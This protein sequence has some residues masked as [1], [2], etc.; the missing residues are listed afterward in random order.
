MWTLAGVNRP[1]EAEAALHSW[2]NGNPMVAATVRRVDQ[3]AE[4]VM[5]DGLAPYIGDPE[6]RR[7]VA[8][9]W[10]CMIAGMQQRPQPLDHELILAAT[11]EFVRTNM[12]VEVEVDGDRLRVV[13]MPE[14]PGA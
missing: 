12:G 10:T 8:F 11:L 3:K 9:M 7:V 4:A 5:R 14:Q 2:A 13:R 6:R 1:H